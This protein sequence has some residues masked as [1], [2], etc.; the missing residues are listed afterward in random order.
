MADQPE[1]PKD[2]IRPRSRFNVRIGAPRP[3]RP[4]AETPQTEPAS[5]DTGSPEAAGAEAPP[6]SNPVGEMTAAPQ[7]EPLAKPGAAEPD[8]GTLDP[9]PVAVPAATVDPDEADRELE[10]AL[11]DQ[12]VEKLLDESQGPQTEIPLETRLQA[13]VIRVDDE[14]VFFSLGGPH[15][16]VASVRQFDDPPEVGKEYEVIVTGRHGTD[17]R[18]YELAVPGASVQVSDWSD[19]VKGAIVEVRITGTNTGGLEGKVNNTIRAFIPASQVSLHRVENLNEYLERKLLCEVVEVNPRKNR[20]VLSHRAV[21]EREREA[22]RQRKFDSLEVGQAVEGT[23]RSLRDFGAFIDLGGLDGLVHISE[24]SWNRIRHP[25][26]VLQEGQTVRARI[27][28][29]DRQSGKIGLSIR[30]LAEHPWEKVEER[31]PPGSTVRGEVTRI[32]QFGAFVKLAP[33]VEGMIHISELDH[34][35]V[36]SVGSVLQPGQE[37]DCKVLSVDR[38]KQRIALSLK[39][40]KAPPKTDD[41]TAGDPKTGKPPR[42]RKVRTDLRGGLDRPSGGESLGLKW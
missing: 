24:I 3:K 41:E 30:A 36:P 7:P 13:T 39:A 18:L 23:V 5:A 19:L 15:E 32:A 20:L 16:G 37:I 38:N 27:E 9:A 10:A 17:E 12:S 6:G 40:L 22:E 14:Y 25:K 29:I 31:F 42:G 34:G 26:D 2:A 4:E 28:K 33:G 8:A 35:R 11:Q 21:L 1:N